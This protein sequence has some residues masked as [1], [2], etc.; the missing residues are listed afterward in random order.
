MST[1]AMAA[2][3][4]ANR[5]HAGA[6]RPAGTGVNQMPMAIAKGAARFRSNPGAIMAARFLRPVGRPNAAFQADGAS[7]DRTV[8]RFDDELPGKLI[9]AC[10][11]GIPARA[12]Q[13]RPRD[14]VLRRSAFALEFAE[15]LFAALVRP[16]A[17][18]DQA[19]FAVDER[20]HL[21]AETHAG[22]PLPCEQHRSP[23]VDDRAL[24][25]AAEGNGAAAAG[26]VPGALE[27]TPFTGCSGGL[28]RLRRRLAGGHREREG[29]RRRRTRSLGPRGGVETF[30]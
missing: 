25:I 23:E 16:D 27:L 17:S 13:D 29:G 30:S 6:V 11:A 14:A 4:T 19:R 21:R 7:L 20:D 12:A 24:S 5:C 1:H 2:M 18:A 22:A 3:K 26:G 9:G 10:R 15:H 28:W 8:L